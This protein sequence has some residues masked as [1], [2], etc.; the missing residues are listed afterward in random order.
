MRAADQE[1]WY[2][3]VLEPITTAVGDTS[4]MNLG[5]VLSGA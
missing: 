1:E 4:K 2:N 5:L 3:G